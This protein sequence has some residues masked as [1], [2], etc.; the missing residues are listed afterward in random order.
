MKREKLDKNKN[1]IIKV[2]FW[3]NVDDVREFD[4]IGTTDYVLTCLQ[5]AFSFD[6]L[7]IVTHHDCTLILLISGFD[8]QTVEEEIGSLWEMLKVSKLSFFGI[9]DITAGEISID[10]MESS[11]DEDDYIDTVFEGKKTLFFHRKDRYASFEEAEAKSK[12][13]QQ[14]MMKKEILCR[15]ENLIGA[16]QFVHFIK[17]LLTIS[18]QDEVKETMKSVLS[19]SALCFSIE[20]GCGLTTYLEI[21]ADTLQATDLMKI[22]SE[23]KD[24]C[25][26]IKKIESDDDVVTE[27]ASLENKY[28]VISI[29]LTYRLN[30]VD[31]AEFRNFLRNLYEKR[32][33]TSMLVFKIPYLEGETKDKMIYALSSTFPLVTIDIP[34][35]SVSD[36]LEY[37]KDYAAL[38]GVS[39][40]DE[41]EDE[42]ESLIIYEQNRS[43][44]Y[45]FKSIERMV[46]DIIFDKSHFT[47]RGKLGMKIKISE[48]DLQRVVEEKYG[49]KKV[50]ESL[51]DLIGV[52]KVKERLEEIIVQLELAANSSDDK[53]PSM[54]MLFTGNP[55]TGKTTVA[56]ILG[57]MLKERGLLSKG[58]FFERTGRD[59][60]GKYIGETAPKTNAICQDAYGSILFIDEAYTLFRGE[61]DERDFG[62]EAIDTLITQMENHRSDFIVIMAGY[63]EQMEKMFKANPGLKSR[64]PHEINFRNFTRDEMTDIFMSMV[65]KNCRAEE[66]LEAIVKKYFSELSDHAIEE[67]SF[68]NARFIRNLYERTVAKAALRSQSLIGGR[69]NR[70]D[71]LVLTATDFTRASESDEFVKMQ[72]KKKHTMGFM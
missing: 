50:E 64:I 47:K 71:V 51:D 52:D 70:Q 66:G 49:K 3:F 18:E 10:D 27:V 6:A 12:A 1:C 45:G 23:S 8:L 53:K 9:Y 69:L 59:F 13:L 7:T 37:V 24:G 29:D 39:F 62:R 55:G 42:I 28:E 68:A 16:K 48:K 2:G 33:A 44:F 17:D 14:S 19:R 46:E 65:N 54:H 41:C 35:F 20:G 60:V 21:L 56:R 34:P 67:Q 5:C 31:T 40:D 57:R 58:Q 4:E 22:M 38:L 15:V 43:R 25:V 11:D 32:S 61:D 63:S 30:Q 72:E 36:Y 26:E